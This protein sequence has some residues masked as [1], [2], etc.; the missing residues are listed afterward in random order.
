MARIDGDDVVV[1]ANQIAHDAVAALLERGA[2]IETRDDYGRT[3]L[4]LCARERGKAATGRILIEAG[5][6]VNATD[7]FGSTAL[8]LAAWRGKAD[9]VDLLLQKGVRVPQSGP[10]WQEM[11]SQAASNGLTTLFRRLTEQ[12]LS[13]ASD[14]AA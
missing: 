13:C 1:M 10:I 2:A 5:A 6:D 12:G 3:A 7:K 9:F 4:I 8:E 14:I 11:L